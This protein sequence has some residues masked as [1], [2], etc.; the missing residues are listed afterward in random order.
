MKHSFHSLLVCTVASAVDLVVLLAASRSRIFVFSLSSGNLISTWR[1]S[2]GPAASLNL[3]KASLGKDG[4]ERP[5]KRQKKSPPNKGSDSSSA[6]IVTED[7]QPKPVK[8]NK[9]H[10]AESNITKLAATA[11]GRFVVALTDHDKSMPKRPCAIAFT[12]DQATIICGDKFG[13]VYALPLLCSDSRKDY[14]SH[15]QAGEAAQE[16]HIKTENIFVPSATLRTVHTLR[17]QE[18]LRHQQNQKNHTP[19][20]NVVDFERR[21]LLGHVSLLTDLTCVSIPRTTFA[22]PQDRTYIISADRDEHIR[23]S[24]GL[25]QAHIIE[26]FCLGHTQFVSKLCIPSWNSQ[27]LISGGGDDYLLVWDWLLGRV[28]QKID[29]RKLIVDSVKQQH[30]ARSVLRNE[31][32]AV[33]AGVQWDGP[34]AVSEIQ[35]MEVKTAAGELRRQIAVACESVPAIFCFDSTKDGTM[36]HVGTTATDAAVTTLAVS[37]DHSRIA[38]AM[39]VKQGVLSD[40][41]SAGE[42]ESPKGISIGILDFDALKGSWEKFD[43]LVDTINS[44]M[45]DIPMV[46]DAIMGREGKPWGSESF[47]GNLETLRKR[48]QDE[49]DLN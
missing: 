12:P 37:P 47:L 36:Q 39:G 33:V 35:A 14:L 46:V 1:S 42:D 22:N 3:E 5:I 24:R 40:S 17:N 9:S 2:Q 30:S 11:D 18:A 21:L 25:P 48:G 34:I 23:V 16:S 45:E 27:L 19:T 6:E 4:P 44:A 8:T 7:A 20:K 10:I 15:F 31:P 29:L 38:Y 28:L 26:G 41:V 13:D 32:E 49:F 43:G